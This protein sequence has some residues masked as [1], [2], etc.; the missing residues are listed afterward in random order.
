[1]Q[2]LEVALEGLAQL[3]GVALGFLD[4][5][6]KVLVEASATGADLSADVLAQCRQRILGAIECLVEALDRCGLVGGWAL[7]RGWSRRRAAGFLAG[8][9]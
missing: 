1:M 8:G 4:E 9:I 5:L 6:L 2:P 3:A 7:S